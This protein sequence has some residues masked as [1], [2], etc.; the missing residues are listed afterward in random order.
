M[1]RL[2]PKDKEAVF[3]FFKQNSI[4]ESCSMCHE[5]KYKLVDKIISIPDLAT[6]EVIDLSQEIRLFPF[7]IYKCNKCGNTQLFSAKS[8][9]FGK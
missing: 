1:S 8:V 2:S 4:R 6:A 3:A 5:G 7:V 9:G